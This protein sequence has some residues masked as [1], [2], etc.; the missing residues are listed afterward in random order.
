MFGVENS[1]KDL[2]KFD[3]QNINFESNTEVDLD[4]GWAFYWNQLIAPNNF[5]KEQSFTKVSIQDW[6]NYND[7][8]GANLPSFGYATYRLIFSLPKKRPH[9]S[10]EIPPAYSS[11]NIWINNE[12]IAE[13]GEVGTRKETTVHRRFS[14]TIPLDTDI[15]DFEIVIQVANF[16][17]AKGGYVKAPILAPSEHLQTENNRGII[18]DMIFIGSL[19]FIGFFFL[20]FFL[21]FWNKDIAVLYFAILCI[22]W[23]NRALNDAYA[24]FSHIFPNVSWT[25]LS[26]IEYITLFMGGSAACLFFANIFSNH[27]HKLYKKIIIVTFLISLL[28]ILFLPSQ[29]FTRLLVPYIY[30]MIICLVYMTG[31]IVKA[32][33][34]KER[35]SVL[36]LVSIVFGLIIFCSHIFVFFDGNGRDL[37]YI[38]LGYVFVFLLISM[39]LMMR[40]SNSFIELEVSRKVALEQKKEISLQ[41]NQLSKTNLRLKDNLTLLENHN[42]ELDNFNHIVSHDLKAPLVAV[43][44]LVHFIEEDNN[45]KFDENTKSNFKLLKERILKMGGLIEGLL[46]Y[47]K[48]AK[49][50]KTKE[51]FYLNDV[52]VDIVEAVNNKNQHTIVLPIDNPRIYANKTE[53]K[54]IFLNL[55]QNAIKHNDKKETRI[56]ILFTK[57]KE[58]YEFSVKDNGPGIPRK[59]HAKI[60][61]MFTSLQNDDK[62]DSTGIGLS[63]VKKIISENHGRIWIESKEGIGTTINFV[64]KIEDQS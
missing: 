29:Y 9:L 43:N 45:A 3:L 34:Y 23:A 38:N 31:V 39:L 63:I 13:I 51:Y 7:A 46:E 6:T 26:R 2:P 48:I 44:A 28:L 33:F 57:K 25:L 37:V 49:G 52:L 17:H 35:K 20:L 11:S 4:S 19:G 5:T 40:F 15:N 36:A 56:N 24:P 53:I 47:S 18:S 60:F 21:F 14:R 27:I 64:I 41:S 55:I 32:I 59:Y 10:L 1:Q 8:N 54:H 22:C 58:L 42:S 30:F 16:Y 62:R 12:L 50:N 61:D